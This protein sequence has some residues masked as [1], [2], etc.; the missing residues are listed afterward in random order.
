MSPFEECRVEL[1]HVGHVLSTYQQQA[2][3]R[4]TYVKLQRFR[5]ENVQR[6][7]DWRRQSEISLPLRNVGAVAAALR[8]AV[9]QANSKGWR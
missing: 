5:R 8:L 6:D 2:S 3:S 4:R 1:V 7:D 9:E